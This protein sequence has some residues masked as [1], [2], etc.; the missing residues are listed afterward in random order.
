MKVRNGAE[1]SDILVLQGRPIGEPLARRGPFVMNT[2]DELAQAFRDHRRGVFGA[3]PWDDDD[4]VH[5]RNAGRF[6]RHAGGH[7]ERGGASARPVWSA[8]R[9]RG[10]RSRTVS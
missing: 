5:S 2:R 4:P 3:W 10:R 1:A 7:V 6:A 8:R 9:R